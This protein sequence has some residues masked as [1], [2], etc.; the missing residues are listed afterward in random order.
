MFV[1][2]IPTLFE[3]LERSVKRWPN[4]TAVNVALSPNRSIAETKAQMWCFSQAFDRQLGKGLPVYAKRI[5][6]FN[7][8]HVTKHFAS[9]Q[10]MPVEVTAVN[11]EEL[12]RRNDIDDIQVTEGG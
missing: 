4:A 1:E 8:S 7:A 2:P 11:F 9:A 3:K 12:L 5:C 6:S 10:L